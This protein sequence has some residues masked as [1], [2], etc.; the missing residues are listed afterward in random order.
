MKHTT[1]RIANGRVIDP[2]HGV[3]TLAD[4]F[5]AN[6]R[7]AAIG[8][9]PDGFSPTQTLDA[10]GCIV[11]PGFV[12]LAVRLG[13]V[14]P[15]LSAAVVGGVTSLAC[16]PDCRPPL[17]EPGLVERLVRRSEAVGLAHVYPVGALTQQLAGERLA[18]M[19]SLAEAGCVAF[20]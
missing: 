11:C 3:D 18:E 8:Q 14:E 17:D 15:E 12:D 13:S 7:I 10:G 19:H 1:I 6:G 4:V 5:I 16:P 2:R 20:S 9:K